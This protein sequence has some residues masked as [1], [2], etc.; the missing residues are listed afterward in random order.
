MDLED[1]ETAMN[2]VDSQ[3]EELKAMLEESKA[4]V[5]LWF[6]TEWLLFSSFQGGEGLVKGLRL[7]D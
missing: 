2:S 6:Y 3:V 4:Q 7:L 5:G 1:N